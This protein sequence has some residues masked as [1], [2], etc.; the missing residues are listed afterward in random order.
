[1]K[2]IPALL[3]LSISAFPLL[4]QVVPGQYILELEGEPAG[5]FAARRGHHPH[6][7]DSLFKA[8][9]AEIRL[10]HDRVRGSVEQSGAQVVDT[11]HVVTNTL[12]VTAPRTTAAQLAAIPG[13]LRVHPV[14]MYNRTLDH[15]LPLHQVPAAWNL[16]G[17]MA[18]AGLGARIAIIDTG[19]DSQHPGFQDSSLVVPPGFP[20]VNKQSDLAYTN[21]KVIVARSYFISGPAPI[22][23]DVEGHGTG[24]AMVSAGVTSTGPYGPITGVAPK[25]F[26]GNYKVFPD[27][28]SGAPDSLIIKAIDDAVADGMDVLNLSLGSVL[29]S[30]PADDVL[31]LAVER[32]VAAGKIVTIAAGNDGPDPITIGS[33]GTAPDAISV[34]SMFN[35]RV[36]APFIQVENSPPIPAVPGDGPTP[37]APVTAAL[38]DVAQFDPSGLAC[39]SLP[40]GSLNG[41][42]ALILRGVCNFEVKINYAQQA[43]A[44]GALI[45]TDAARPDAGG[46]AAGS[47]T[48]PAMMVDYQTGIG[49]KN[50]LAQG[51]FVVSL[52]FTASP[53]PVKPN[54]LSSFTSNG[55]NV[56]Y[57]VKPDLVAVGSSIYTAKPVL[58]NGAASDGFVVESGTS[59]SSPMVAGAAALLKAARP[60]L[61]AQQYRSLL[62]NSASSLNSDNPVGVQQ[63]GAGILN[64][65]A[66]LQSNT[67]VYPT[68]VS[69]GYGFGPV[70][71][72]QSLTI[73]NL[74]AAADTFSINVQPS[75]S[76]PAPTVSS[77]SVQLQPGQ[78]QDLKVQFTNSNLPA[79]A[80][81]GY[82]QIQ[83]TQSPVTSGVPYWYGSGSHTPANITILSAPTHGAVRSRQTIFFRITDAQ[84]VRI[85]ALPDVTITSG[86]GSVLT[87]DSVA[88]QIPFAGGAAVRLGAAIG[89]NIIHLSVGDI[90]KDVTIPS[91]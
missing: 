41:A 90:S 24:V 79:G 14:R 18:N 4:A 35:D 73:T 33:P 38:V 78:S 39:S 27:P 6:R 19:I 3:F 86:G 55:P 84:G 61:S 20:L 2:G 59:F 37:S 31:V 25:A 74:G 12:F 23:K 36:I 88:D 51:R 63:L 28:A 56:D 50:Q 32:A 10:Q 52:S 1:M 9:E 69:F 85:S 53:I 49:L 62:I 75:G 45:Y 5:T 47:A 65:A 64:M 22:A 34:G 83:G 8:R 57:L 16:I 30:A 91:P 76:G 21:N 40:A 29:A 81:Q 7:N 15:A 46:I 77:N 44:V 82:F 66:A 60:G 80:Y 26:L 11:T 48:L 67:S 68:S 72:S 70:D 89:N 54:R 17:G 71:Q 43:G 42:A 13:V 58:N 87:V